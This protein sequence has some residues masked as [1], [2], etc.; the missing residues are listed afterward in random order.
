MSK[1]EIRIKFFGK[2]R[3]LSSKREYT[4]QLDDSSIVRDALVELQKELEG[5]AGEFFDDDGS[6]LL[7]VNV[8]IN[9]EN[10]RVKSGLDTDLESGDTVTIF[11]PFG[12]G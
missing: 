6:L 3:Q 11:P 2:F 10:I 9:G 1:K 5:L 4:I 8:F 7:R 12:G